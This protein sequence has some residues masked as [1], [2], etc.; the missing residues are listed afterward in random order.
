MTS[1]EHPRDLQAWLHWQER[2]KPV[3]ALK[4][5]LN[6]RRHSGVIS[7]ISPDADLLVVVDSTSPTTVSALLTAVGHLDPEQ[8]VVLSPSPVDEHLPAPAGRPW[9]TTPW[10]AGEPVSPLR[11]VLA[12]GH[13]LPLGGAAHRLSMA[14]RVPYLVVQ[15]SVLTPATPP[16]PYGST[17]LAWSDADAAFWRSD[18]ADVQTRVVGSQ[19]LDDAAAAPRRKVD[20]DA[21]PTYLGQLHSAEMPRGA[22]AD[23]A[24]AFC[25]ATGATYR[26]HPEES[27]RAS[28][29]QHDTW[30]SEGID[31]DDAA[32][33]L[34]AVGTPVVG[35]FS[36][37]V[38]EAAVRRIP[39]YVEFPDPPRWL[40]E[41]WSRY[42]LHRWGETPTPAPVM[43]SADGPAPA[44]LVAQA[45]QDAG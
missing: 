36:T 29:R 30:R 28:R 33:P 21:P 15:H 4:G 37:G 34:S 1:L 13:H 19:F 32:G 31:V 6:R 35:V 5:M 40:T 25:R 10:R 17:L 8:V 9:V 45:L 18:R 24:V 27:D 22:M 14:N 26:P 44:A 42:A 11:A 12:A 41:F 7:R 20:L 38:L 2:Q 39:T 43:P 3:R 16:L 23:A